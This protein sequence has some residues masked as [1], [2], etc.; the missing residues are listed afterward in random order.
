MSVEVLQPE[1][2]KGNADVE[3]ATT[4]GTSA[5]GNARKLCAHIA[6]VLVGSI[7]TYYALALLRNLVQKKRVAE[8]GY[9]VSMSWCRVMQLCTQCKLGVEWLALHMTKSFEP[10]FQDITSKVQ[11]KQ[12]LAA[13]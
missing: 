2:L 8:P 4:T 7:R 1:H 5:V 9:H 12:V 10:L 13:T 11:D 3:S 6:P